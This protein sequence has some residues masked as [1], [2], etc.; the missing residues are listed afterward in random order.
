MFPAYYMQISLPTYLDFFL[1]VYVL[2]QLT[3]FVG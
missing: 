3:T 1:C 2:Y